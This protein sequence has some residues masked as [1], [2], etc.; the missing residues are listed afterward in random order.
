M[1]KILTNTVIL[2]PFLVVPFL[3]AT[4]VAKTHIR[5]RFSYL[6]MALFVPLWP[7]LLTLTHFLSH[8]GFVFVGTSIFLLPAALFAQYLANRVVLKG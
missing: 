2:A 5:R 8:D 6:M 4:L 1:E 3:F 7:L